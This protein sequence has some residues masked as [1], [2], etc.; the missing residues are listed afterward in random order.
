MILLFAAVNLALISF[1]LVLSTATMNDGFFSY[2]WV[3]FTMLLSF[4]FEFWRFEEY[5]VFIG[6]FLYE[7]EEIPI[8][9]IGD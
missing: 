7:T 9:F 2:T 1:I 6:Y 3:Y 8:D 5:Y 4:E